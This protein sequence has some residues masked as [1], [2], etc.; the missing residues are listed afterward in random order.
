MVALFLVGG[1][2]AAEAR[3]KKAKAKPR[4]STVTLKIQ[5]L[6]PTTKAKDVARLRRAIKKVKGVVK[7]TISKKAGVLTVRHKRAADPEAITAAVTRA[8]FAVVPKGDGPA[9]MEPPLEEPPLDEEP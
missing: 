4:L 1:P 5:D 6:N 9:E 7:I 3:G 2:D 8:G